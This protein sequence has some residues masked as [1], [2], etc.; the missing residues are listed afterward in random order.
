MLERKGCSSRGPP[1]ESRK[2]A[3]RVASRR[4]SAA[5]PASTTRSTPGRTTPRRA[6]RLRELIAERVPHART[7][8]DVAC[9]TG[10]HLADLARTTTS[11]ASIST[12]RCSRSRVSGCPIVPPPRGRHGRRST[13]AASS[14]SSRASS[15]A[16]A[17]RSRASG[18]DQAAQSLARH[19]APGGLLIVEPWITPERGARHV[20]RALRRRA[21][22]EDRAH[23]RAPPLAGDTVDLEFHYLV[24]TPDGIEHFTERHEV[25]MFTD[26]DYRDG[27]RGGG[28]RGRAR[29]RGA[30][31]PRA[32]PRPAW[33][34]ATSPRRAAGSGRSAIAS[35]RC[36]TGSP[37]SI[38]TR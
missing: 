23:E 24:A 25:G 30:D 19:V 3:C 20:S 8:L 31:G 29:S 10:I 5:R 14:T 1:G 7:L 34:V 11:R 6:T 4:C 36:S 26:E 32:L 21:R 28:T 38:P 37:P 35:A 16:S 22:P 18:C 15:R 9:G 13:S 27:V 12:P 33:R 2:P 17:T